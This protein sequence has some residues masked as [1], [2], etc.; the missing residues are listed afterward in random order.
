MSSIRSYQTFSD[1]RRDMRGS[2][3]W[4]SHIDEIADTSVKLEDN[5]KKKESLFD[6]FE[7]FESEDD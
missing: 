3:S 4:S 5:D 6:S 2:A 1:L 7:D